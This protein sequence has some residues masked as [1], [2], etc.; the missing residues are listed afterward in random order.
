MLRLSGGRL[1]GGLSHW[2]GAVRW[3]G[4]YVCALYA[5]IASFF[6][7]MV[8]GVERGDRG[9]EG[10]AVVAGVRGCPKAFRI[11]GCRA[12][13]QAAVA[14]VGLSPST[15]ACSQPPETFLDHTAKRW[16]VGF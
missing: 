11:G 1:L 12:L 13:Y 15:D 14:N 3:E 10:I 7:G 5:V 2:P 6:V 9:C 16:Q 8:V 4:R